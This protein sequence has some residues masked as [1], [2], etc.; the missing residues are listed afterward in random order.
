MRDTKGS[1]TSDDVGDRV[2]VVGL[3]AHILQLTTVNEGFIRHA[4]IPKF[5]S[6]DMPKNEKTTNGGST[7]TGE[8][9]FDE[10][11]DARIEKSC[12]FD[13]ILIEMIVKAITAIVHKFSRKI[14][15]EKRCTY[16]NMNQN[17]KFAE[18]SPHKAPSI[19][20]KFDKT[21]KA[22]AST[23]EDLQKTFSS[24]NAF[25]RPAEVIDI[26]LDFFLEVWKKLFCAIR[27]IKN[28]R[29]SGE[30]QGNRV[31]PEQ[32]VA[33]KEHCKNRPSKLEKLEEKVHALESILR[34]LTRFTSVNA[35][36]PEKKNYLSESKNI[37]LNAE[38]RKTE[39]EAHDISKLISDFLGR[40]D[41]TFLP[42]YHL[43]HIHQVTLDSDA[44]PED[45]IQ[46]IDTHA[47]MGLGAF[48]SNWKEKLRN[49]QF[50][51]PADL[52]Q[53]LR[54]S[55]ESRFGG[56][57]LTCSIIMIIQTFLEEYSLKWD[58]L[59]HVQNEN[60]EDFGNGF[61][62]G[63]KK[64]QDLNPQCYFC[65]KVFLEMPPVCFERCCAEAKFLAMVRSKLGESLENS[66]Q[67]T[68][69]KST[70]FKMAE[71]L[72][73]QK[74][75][76][77]VEDG[78]NFLKCTA[79][80]MNFTN[81]EVAKL[82]LAVAIGRQKRGTAGNIETKE[83]MDSDCLT[84]FKSE[85]SDEDAGEGVIGSSIE[86]LWRK[87]VAAT[88]EVTSMDSIYK[89]KLDGSETSPI[90]KLSIKTD[91]M[92]FNG[93]YKLQGS[94][95][96]RKTS[97]NDD[98]FK[99]SMKDPETEGPDEKKKRGNESPT[100][101]KDEENAEK[102]PKKMK[103]KETGREKDKM[104]SKETGREKDKGEH[105]KEHQ[106]SKKER[107]KEKE[108]KP[109]GHDT[110][111]DSKRKK[112]SK[113]DKGGADDEDDGSV[114]AVAKRKKKMEP[115]NVKEKDEL[116]GKGTHR[117]KG[118]KGSKMTD[119]MFAK[120]IE[121]TGGKIFGNVPYSLSDPRY[122]DCDWTT[123]S[124]VYH[125]KDIAVYHTK[126]KNKRFMWCA[127]SM[128]EEVY[129][130]QD[131]SIF[132]IFRCNGT[133]EV[134]YPDGRPAI[135]VSK[136]EGKVELIVFSIDEEEP[137]SIRVTGRFDTYGHGIIYDND[138]NVR[139]HTVKPAV[140]FFL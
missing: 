131:G 67:G 111:A 27:Q 35:S 83:E 24:E 17:N 126:Q 36:I 34:T 89:S 10:E 108:G 5:I 23:N 130:Y 103:A 14:S 47:K 98:P 9:N 12:E 21:R 97:P 121:K 69:K 43:P 50:L 93:D 77:M 106:A 70:L 81:A 118:S 49:E 2:A 107:K 140:V 95:Q 128:K 137:S 68:W 62:K 25:D 76:I 102:S 86:P 6:G 16:P 41:A 51:N 134:Y 33:L 56:E 40:N 44:A 122:I 26:D 75:M 7:V 31:T 112:R 101:V 63:S 65:Q 91:E 80:K 104:K 45:C 105:H 100:K 115:K 11:V 54:Q 82:L 113:K 138:G 59:T 136:E 52:Y 84:Q 125:K 73:N 61:R 20:P 99:K 30:F 129:T 117:S 29:F 60:A 124:R 15:D 74:L 72:S 71:D 19:D 39:R 92:Q 1:V 4:G 85:T 133:G 110:K 18:N 3:S 22:D 90:G 120:Q 32:D 78:K 119:T 132:A 87:V 46:V 13:L 64:G 57:L 127:D 123:L 116:A 42:S 135:V 53:Y 139:F 55:E 94:I 37:Y 79:R 8:I 66:I 88:G 109:E 48:H 28:R 96:E 38:R 58:S 114:D